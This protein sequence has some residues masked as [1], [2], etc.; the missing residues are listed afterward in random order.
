MSQMPLD[1]IRIDH[2]ALEAT[3]QDL[4]ATVRRIDDRLDRLDAELAP[5]RSDWTGAAQ[6]AYRVAKTRWDAAI[7]EMRD[8]LQQ[9]SNA[10]AQSNAAY[11]EADR[12]GAAAFG[13]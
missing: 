8:L 6:E 9:T 5:L 3:A 12:R 2:A 7:R 10:V 1:G 13:Q 11:R 4:A